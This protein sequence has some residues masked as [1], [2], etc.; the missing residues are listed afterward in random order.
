MGC[1]YALDMLRMEAGLPRMGVDIK[2]HHTLAHASLCCLLSL[3]KVRRQL[4]LCYQAIQRHV[5]FGSKIQRVGIVVGREDRLRAI[6]LWARHEAVKRRQSQ[7]LWLRRLNDRM[8]KANKQKSLDRDLHQSH[9]DARHLAKKKRSSFPSPFREPYSNPK[10]SAGL[11]AQEGREE[12]HGGEAEQED[13]EV[14]DLYRAAEQR[15]EALKGWRSSPRK[16]FPVHEEEDEVFSSSSFYSCRADKR[17]PSS[18]LS[19]E[20]K[21]TKGDQVS[22][23]YFPFHG[24]VVL[25]N[26]HKRPIGV[27]TSCSWSPHFKCRLAQGL[28]LREFAK[29][30]QVNPARC[31]FLSNYRSATDLSSIPLTGWRS[32]AHSRVVGVQRT[33][34]DKNKDTSLQR[35]VQAQS[36]T[37]VQMC[38][39]LSV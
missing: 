30:N 26:P 20:K 7:R 28:V 31:F 5:A 1:L 17:L 25:S 34:V 39:N 33:Q 19:A 13:E 21:H 36:D 16:D 18:I 32:V 2:T 23:G 9:H 3:Y 15:E 14:E 29:H 38:L 4:L 12:S 27:I 24:C 11:G 8:K 10:E 22:K 37:S 35:Q 6:N